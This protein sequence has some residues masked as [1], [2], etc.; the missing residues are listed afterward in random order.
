MLPAK[1]LPV[2]S[3]QLGFMRLFFLA[4]MMLM[5][6]SPSHAAEPYIDF[7]ENVQ[8]APYHPSPQGK[9]L[10]VAMISVLSRQVT[11][12]NQRQ[13]LDAIGNKMGQNV[14]LLQRSSYA[15]ITQLL[16]SGSVDAALMST[17]AYSI[18][19]HQE[20]FAPLVMQQRHGTSSYRGLIIV[21]KESG[22]YTLK[23]LAGKTFAF[24]DPLSYSGHFSVIKALEK[25]GE[26]PETFFGSSYFTFSN[27]K[28]LRAVAGKFVD[29]AAI[30][31]L[32]YDYYKKKQPAFLDAVRVI[33]ELPEAGT[34]PVVV[35]ADYLEK[36]KLKAVLLN[37]HRDPEVASA[38][39]ELLIERFVDVQP[40]LLPSI[41]SR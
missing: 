25:K 19:G 7:N 6:V 24:V 5:S 27:D 34:G 37:L 12:R 16:A 26:N 31:V 35:R 15:E 32:V 13:V 1:H 23:D 29:G 28:S 22:T 14:L 40:N 8:I 11:Y 4:L 38:L 36:E 20:N 41:K 10:K 21:P 17:G 33:M 39:D 9:V 2:K 3:A 18:Y 30:N